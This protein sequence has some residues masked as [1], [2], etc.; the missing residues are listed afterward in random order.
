MGVETMP[1]KETMRR[2]KEIMSRVVMIAL[3]SVTL[4]GAMRWAF[5]VTQANAKQMS[6]NA[7]RWQE[8]LDAQ[9]KK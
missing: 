1:Q 5:N 4:I 8:Q 2:D 9:A 6:G 7:L 3:L